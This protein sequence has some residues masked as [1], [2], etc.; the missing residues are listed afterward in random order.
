MNYKFRPKNILIILLTIWVLLFVILNFKRIYIKTKTISIRQENINK[1]SQTLEY[2]SKEANQQ[3]TPG[4]KVLFLS[5]DSLDYMR[6]NLMT[7][8]LIAKWKNNFSL[9]DINNWD[10]VI[11]YNPDQTLKYKTG[12]YSKNDLN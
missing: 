12:V 10:F 5:D 1:D 6:F 2:L 7:Y 8:P 3:I 11:I 9:K 4:S